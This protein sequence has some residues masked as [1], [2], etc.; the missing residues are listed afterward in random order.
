[1]WFCD[2][3]RDWT[4]EDFLHLAP[5]DEFYVWT[6][7][8]PNYQNDRVWAR[9][10]EDIEDDERYREMVKNQLCIGIFIIFTTKKLHWVMKEKGESWTGQYFR[11]VILMQHVFPFLKDE[12]NVIDPD[13][14]IFVHDKAP[15]MHATMTQ[16]LLKENDIT[17]WRNDTW[18]DNSPDLNV[19]EHVG[20]IIKD[21]VERKI[22]S[23]TVENHYKQETLKKHLIDVLTHMESNVEL[24]ETLLCSYPFRLQAVRNVNERHTDY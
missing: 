13:Q 8:R 19:A 9:S 22:L 17:F 6:I 5:S 11:D 2:W 24:F 10:I 23:E 20:T 16:H 14:V 4:Q 12:E 15:C 3:L 18:L 1:L 21:E 7:R